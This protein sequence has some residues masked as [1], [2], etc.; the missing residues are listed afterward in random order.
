MTVSWTNDSILDSRLPLLLMM[1][2]KYPELFFND[3][4]HAANAQGCQ[5][6]AY[7]KIYGHV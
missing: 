7:D 2:L 1:A 5:Q 3:P 6:D 4:E